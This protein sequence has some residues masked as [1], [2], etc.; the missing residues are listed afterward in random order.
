MKTVND[1]IKELQKLPKE[2]RAKPVVISAP[3]GLQ[4]EPHC[5]RLIDIKKNQTIFDAYSNTEKMIITY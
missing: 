3:N 2:L 1:F 4:F 5:K